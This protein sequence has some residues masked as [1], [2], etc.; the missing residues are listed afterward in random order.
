MNGWQMFEAFA[1]VGWPIALVCAIRLR[2]KVQWWLF[3]ERLQE[4]RLSAPAEPVVVKGRRK[5]KA[6]QH[7]RPTDDESQI[8]I[9]FPTGEAEV[10]STA[11][12][13]SPHGPERR[14]A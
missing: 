9:T 1:V 8:L 2:R 7:P 13:C 5:G 12:G 6:R 14:M 4:A 3:L 10:V 11:E